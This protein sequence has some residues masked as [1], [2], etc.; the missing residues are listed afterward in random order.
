VGMWANNVHTL[1]S[2]L[3][4]QRQVVI[5]LKCVELKYMTVTLTKKKVKP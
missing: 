4:V 1:V 3:S 5:F 2:E